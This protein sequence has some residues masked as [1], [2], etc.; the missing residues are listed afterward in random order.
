MNKAA[1]HIGT[2]RLLGLLFGCIVLSNCKEQRFDS[3]SAWYAAQQFEHQV[4]AAT[5]HALT[6]TSDPLLIDTIYRSM[7]GPYNLKQVDFPAADGRLVW[8]IGYRAEIQSEASNKRLSDGFMCHNN[9]NIAHKN[10][11]PWP[12]HTQ[13]SVTRLFT[14]TEGQTNFKLPK[15]FGIP[16]PADLELS[17]VC[18]V[19]NHNLPDTHFAARHEVTIDYVKETELE[20][21]LIPLYQQAV[22]VTKQ[23]A[24]PPGLYGHPT[25]CIDSLPDSASDASTPAGHF[26]APDFSGGTYDPYSD[27][28]GR[29]YTGHWKIPYGK[30]VLQ[31]D[32]TEMLG[33]EFNTTV[34][35]IAAHLHPFGERLEL[36]DTT[37]DS[38]LYAANA[39]QHANAIGLQ[40]IDHYSDPVGFP[41]YKGHRYHLL[42]TY[43]CTDSLQRHTA[44]A[45]MFLYLRDQP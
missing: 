27:A 45:T 17:M 23:T 5:P 35:S 26:C 4:G 31:T 32:V 1:I 8:L 39:T 44:M 24:G 9:L 21:P 10:D 14:L 19:L 7:Q 13:G 41:L 30:E 38:L 34:H 16:I 40:H 37:T 3:F 33:L 25:L 29:T 12:M 42:S 28:N 43:N 2:A 22:F 15:G 20:T 6:V 36:W 18:Q 11:V